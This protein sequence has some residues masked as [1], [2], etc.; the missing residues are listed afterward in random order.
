[1]DQ[2]KNHPLYRK[3]NI[4]SAMNALWNFYR[5]RFLSLYLISL[6]MSGVTQYGSQMINMQELQTITDPMVMLEKIKGYIV[7]MII[8]MVVS[9]FLS[10]VFH[11]Y[12]LHKPLDESQNIFKCIVRSLRYYLPYLAIF[13]ILA[14]AGS[15]ALLLGLMVLIVGVFFAIVYIGMIAL[16]IL[17]VMMVEEGSIDR[18]IVRTIKLSHSNFWANMGWTAVFLIL[19]IIISMILSGIVLLPFAGDFLKTF[20]NPEDTSGIVNLPSNPLFLIL[21]A[22][23]NAITMPLFPIFAFVL[24]FNGK[25]REEDVYIPASESGYEPR[26]RVEDLYA[27]PKNEESLPDEKQ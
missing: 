24:Y 4:D 7:P 27:K 21:S 12:I 13:V 5:S 6:V 23:V 1:M 18:T 11:Y 10:T 14:F 2:I 8:L 15:I 20:A 17:P 19:Y 16:F 3:H 25:A 22:A 9:M 26:V